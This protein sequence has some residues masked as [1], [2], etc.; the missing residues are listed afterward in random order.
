VF[1]ND[2]ALLDAFRRGERAALT[3]VFRAYIDDVAATV[4]AGVVVVSESG[5][6]TRVGTGMPEHE[7][8]ALI[9]ETFARAFMDKAR[10]AY[11]GLRPYGAYLAT[12]ARNLVIDRERARRRDNIAA[13]EDLTVFAADERTDPGFRLEEQQ[14]GA[15]VNSVKKRLGEPDLSI[16]KL[17][18]EERESCRAIASALGLSEIVVRRRD[19]RLRRTLLR[20]LQSGGF[21]EHAQLSIADRLLRRREG[22]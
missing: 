7:V 4:R 2:R 21:L 14:L 16:F 19:A 5:Q 6:R 13:V 17:R 8:E 18:F 11:D 1:E 20:A 22:S 10:A 15:V 12:I 3:Q 9:Q